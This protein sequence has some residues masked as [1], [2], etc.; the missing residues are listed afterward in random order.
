MGVGNWWQWLKDH[1][2]PNWFAIAFSLIVWPIVIYYWSRRKVRG[3]PHFE[4]Q[5]TPA[6][7]AI[8]AQQYANLTGSIVY[9][10]LARLRERQDNFP[11][12]PSAVRGIPGGWRELKFADQNNNFTRD[13]LVLDTGERTVTSIAVS[14]PLHNDF[15]NYRPGRL[16]MLFTRPKYFVIQYTAM[17]GEK[18]YSVASVY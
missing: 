13:Q 3:I 14:R 11:I 5:P 15:Y 6:R 10:R 8:G 12:P 17:V 7:T 4:V 1:D 18:K 9:I 16:S 2:A